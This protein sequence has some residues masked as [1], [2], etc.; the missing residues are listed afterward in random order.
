MDDRE[1]LW[2][3]YEDN[4]KQAQLHE[5]RRGAATALIAGGAGALVTSM[6]SNG[7]EPD[8]RPLAIMIVVIGLFG[9]AIAAKATERMRMHNNRCKCFLKEIDEHV[10]SLKEAIDQRYKR[11]HPVSNAIGLSWLWQSLHLLIAAAGFS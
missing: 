1:L 11:K 9:W 4:R 8:D 6:F 3:V 5:D 7:L 2:R 10:A